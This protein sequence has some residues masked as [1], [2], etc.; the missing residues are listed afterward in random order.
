[1][2]HMMILKMLFLSMV[3]H[4][5]VTSPLVSVNQQLKLLIPQFDFSLIFTLQDF[6]GQIT[7]TEDRSSIETDSSKHSSKPN[8][9]V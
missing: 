7:K 3:I 2:L 4:Y 1:M 8:K 5:H 9:S 6:I